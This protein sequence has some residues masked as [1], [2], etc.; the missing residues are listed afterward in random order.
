MS[1]HRD[2]TQAA[3]DVLAERQRQQ[4]VEGWAP[5]KDDAYQ[6]G[7][8]AN[9]AACYALTDP[10]IE[11][12]RGAPFDWPWSAKWWKPKSR[13]ADLVRAGALIL[14]EIE[15]IDRAEGRA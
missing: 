12:A 13:R 11:A 4:D 3:L 2:V 9:A 1:T 14:A 5:D 6:A 7:D 15:R 10:I 8:L